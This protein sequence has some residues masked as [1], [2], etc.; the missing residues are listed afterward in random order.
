MAYP[1]RFA[2]RGAGVDGRSAQLFLDAR[3]LTRGSGGG[4]PTPRRRTAPNRTSAMGDPLSTMS[5]VP[6]TNVA[7][8]QPRALSAERGPGE[9]EPP[10]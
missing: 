7:S 9:R 8:M 2:P 5:Q 3:E 6:D 10:K 1:G 4:R